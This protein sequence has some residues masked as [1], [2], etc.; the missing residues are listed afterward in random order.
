MMLVL[1]KNRN[2][3]CKLAS[4]ACSLHQCLV[5][6]RR[7]FFA[8]SS[9]AFNSLS[10]KTACQSKFGTN[11]I[12]SFSRRRVSLQT[13]LKYTFPNS[14]SFIANSAY[15]SNSMRQLKQ[16]LRNFI[17]FQFC[18][19]WPLGMII[20]PLTFRY[21]C[22][23]NHI[24]AT[25]RFESLKRCFCI[26]QA[27]PRRSCISKTLPCS[28]TSFNAVWSISRKKNN[29]SSSG[30]LSLPNNFFMFNNAFLS[31]FIRK[32]KEKLQDLSNI[33]HFITLR[34]ANAY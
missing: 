27:K 5:T 12:R 18:K 20:R 2:H 19:I 24:S 9:K 32:F 31:R 1:S 26:G 15:L 10:C 3:G 30:H 6:I 11:L 29:Y 8:T 4:A 33:Q 21:S 22:F 28:M 13:H 25:C 7:N 14:G 17:A 16:K 34:G 23:V